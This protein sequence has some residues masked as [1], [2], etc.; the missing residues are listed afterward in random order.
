MPH[1]RRSA[2]ALLLAL[3]A[4]A[5]GGA[6]VSAHALLA[7]SD[8]VANAVLATAPSTVTLTFTEQ[9]DAKLSS[10]QVLDAS[11]G[12]HATGPAVPGA[13]GSNTLTVS[14]GP[15]PD[16]VY[17]VAWRTVSA[18]DGHATA[19][20]F[21]FSVGAAAAPPTPSGAAS[22]GASTVSTASVLAR[23]LMYLGLVGLLGALFA[24]EALVAGRGRR[25]RR[26]RS[27]S[28]LAAALG[29]FGV[30]VTSAWDAGVGLTDLPGTTL[31]FD[32]VTRM[33][34][35]LIAGVLLLLAGRRD[36]TGGTM[37]RVAAILVAVALFADAR[38][39]HAANTTLPG[40]NIALQWLHAVAISVWLGGLAGVLLELGDPDTDHRPALMARFSR[41]ATVGIL[42][43]AATGVV[44]AAFELQNPGDLLSTDYGRLIVAKTVLFA[45][46]AL[47]G[48]VNHFRHVPAGEGGVG[49]MRRVGSVE[50][51]VGTTIIVLAA[52]L[53]TTPPPADAVAGGTLTP[54]GTTVEGSDYATS[55][56]LR[57]TVT[58]GTAGPN[59]FRATLA[60]YDTGGPV[61][62]SSVTLRF[63]LPSRPDVGGSSLALQ[64]AAD[65]SFAGTGSNLSLSGTWNVTAL[66]VE[67]TTSV[68]VPLTV[69]VAAPATRVDVSRL[70]GQPTIV[71][72]HLDGGA[73]AQLYLDPWAPGAADLHVT[74]FDAAGKGL[75]VSSITATAASGAEAP[76]PVTMTPVEPGHAVGHLRTV[77]GVP[78]SVSVTGTAPGGAQVSFTVPL[79]PDR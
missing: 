25:L 24:G 54:A 68:E 65:G 50:L 69:A 48:A 19:G 58:P 72:V 53:V 77:A 66:V 36:A 20:S 28:W 78:I 7:A 74:F 70:K 22:G 46:L 73:S 42:L 79:T 16:G 5:A 55:V 9:P 29:A 4:L 27:I 17:T 71:T 57:L 60:D 18:A 75:P 52:A 8:P 47:L 56:R 61:A 59:A 41:W 15:V 64:P 37:T 21:A 43:V 63:S 51:L 12:S 44:R 6:S 14:V 67:P 45:V 13:P 32:A 10:V 30:V 11:G 38:A 1:A 3:S 76:A 62:A 26:M 49:A 23:A 40:L 34:P 39:S 33:T 2:L 31:G 35:I